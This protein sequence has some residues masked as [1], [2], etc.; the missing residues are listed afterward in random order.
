[1]FPKENLTAIRILVIY[2][3]DQAYWPHLRFLH[4]KEYKTS[5]FED[6]GVFKLIVMNAI[7]HKPMPVFLNNLKRKKN[8]VIT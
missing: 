4:F 5:H 1:M 8:K 2:T 6:G 3:N 7:D